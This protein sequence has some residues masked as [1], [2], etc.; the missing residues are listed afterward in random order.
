M[1]IK[2]LKFTTDIYTTTIKLNKKFLS[3]FEDMHLEECEENKN[4]FFKKQFSDTIKEQD[5]CDYISPAITK[6]VKGDFR[7]DAWWVQKYAPGDSHMV[8]A[9]GAAPNLKSFCLYLKCSKDSS[10]IVF[11]QPGFPLLDGQK[12]HYV[13]P[14]K[15]LL[16]VFPSH[17]P[18]QVLK[19][20]D[21]ERLI[22]A[23]NI[24]HG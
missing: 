23:G 12:P 7:L 21:N 6:I 8:H 2:N 10:K 9:H 20:N 13:K 15:G 17:I 11:Y 19:N 18:H 4:N 3:L 16:I 1:E 14:H 22:L 24:Y 5:I